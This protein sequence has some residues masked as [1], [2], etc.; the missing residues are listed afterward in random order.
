[1]SLP[2]EEVSTSCIEAPCIAYRYASTGGKCW[3][4]VSDDEMD[5]KIIAEIQQRAS[6]GSALTDSDT[7]PKNKDSDMNSI[8]HSDTQKVP[9]EST[10]ELP[11][12]ATNMPNVISQ[13]EQE[14]NDQEYNDQEHDDQEHN[15]QDDNVAT[16]KTSETKQTTSAMPNANND[17]FKLC[18]RKYGIDTFVGLIYT[19]N[20][21]I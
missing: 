20:G 16:T 4:F 15:D 17:I 12:D 5:Q 3:K 7:A 13:E 9:S 19:R 6:G 8:T 2:Y 18:L 10:D 14:L 1:M 21:Y 11:K